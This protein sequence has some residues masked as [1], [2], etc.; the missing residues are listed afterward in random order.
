MTDKILLNKVRILAKKME[1]NTLLGYEL[2]DY[3]K[4]FRRI[5]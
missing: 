1:E 3:M 5:K 4:E 2:N